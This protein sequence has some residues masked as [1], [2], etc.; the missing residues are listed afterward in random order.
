M[1][2]TN[3]QQQDAI[4]AESFAKLMGGYAIAA[5][6]AK[7]EWAARNFNARMHIISLGFLA[8]S[9]AYIISP[10]SGWGQQ[11]FKDGVKL[12]TNVKKGAEAVT[13]TAVEAK[14]TFAPSFKQTLKKGDKVAGYTVTSPFGMRTHPIRGTKEPHNGLDVATNKTLLYAVGAPGE[15]LSINC[16]Y[17][18][19]GGGQVAEFTSKELG[20]T[21][22]YLHLSQCSKGEKKAGQPIARSGS[23]GGSTGDHLDFRQKKDGKHLDPWMGFVNAAFTGNPPQPQKEKEDEKS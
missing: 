19:K 20:F 14:R 6:K 11:F 1:T 2:N 3:D 13:E 7:Q 15:T 16:W 18:N 23:S 21:F 5:E 12:A 9:G 22:Q 17:D 10:L 4:A 8:L